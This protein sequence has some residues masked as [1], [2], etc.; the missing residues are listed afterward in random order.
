MRASGQQC[1]V[2]VLIIAE[3]AR[4]AHGAEISKQ[5]FVMTSDVNGAEIAKPMT[6]Q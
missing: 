5:I 3:F 2:N 1:M 6:Y 4:G